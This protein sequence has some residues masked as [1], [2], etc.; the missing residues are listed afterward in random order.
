MAMFSWKIPD[1]ISIIYPGLPFQHKH[2][3]KIHQIKIKQ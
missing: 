2:N 3:Y 1:I